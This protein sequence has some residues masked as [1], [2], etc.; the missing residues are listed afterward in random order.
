M[1]PDERDE[2]LSRLF[3]S[4]ADVA[5]LLSVDARTV[6]RAVAGGSIPGVKIGTKIRVPAAWVRQQAGIREVT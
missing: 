5:R 6:R 1:T 4:P 2:L 3:L